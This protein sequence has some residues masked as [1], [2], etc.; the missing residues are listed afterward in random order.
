MGR[1]TGRGIKAKDLK[2]V[3]AASRDLR[4]AAGRGDL[5]ALRL[6]LSKPGIDLDLKDEAGWTAVTYA[7]HR[8]KPECLKAL[9][10]AGAAHSPYTNTAYSAGSQNTP[11]DQAETYSFLPGRPECVEIL[12]AAGAERGI[13]VENACACRPVRER[14]EIHPHDRARTRT[15][16]DCMLRRPHG[17]LLVHAVEAMMAKAMATPE[18]ESKAAQL[19]ARELELR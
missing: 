6:E 16:A 13:I 1:N 19:E 10:E 4:L 15:R 7:A 8:G 11:L 18:A 17:R 12:K 3:G 9:L 2:H 14:G 5:E